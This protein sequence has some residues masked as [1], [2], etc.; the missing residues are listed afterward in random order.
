MNIL[1]Y[2]LG[3]APYRS[4]G[5][6]RY[7][8]DLMKLQV[9][10][11]H[12]VVAFYPGGLHIFKNKCSIIYEKIIDGIIVFEMVNP[13]PVPLLYGIK[14]IGDM[15]DEE[16]IDEK[17]F[18]E[19]LNAANPEVLHVHTLMGL[20]KIYLEIVHN[21]GIK[22]VYTTHDYFGLCPKVNFINH[23]GIICNN[24]C[25]EQCKLCNV[26]A[27]SISF[28]IV[29]NMKWLAPFKKIIRRIKR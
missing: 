5:L 9:E 24:A 4:G 23:N 22:I 29:R 18:F 25:N 10:C 17:S 2:T 3:F 15:M 11:G 19:M 13:L 14:E 12:N 26:D 27:K 6:T 8:H 28:L 16:N 21:K 1:H 7:A 20:S